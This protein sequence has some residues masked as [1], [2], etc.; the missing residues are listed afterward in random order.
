MSALTRTAARGTVL[1][2]GALLLLTASSYVVAVVLARGL[3]PVDYGVYGIIYS[4]LL[5]IELIGRLGITQAVAR[6]VAERGVLDPRLEGSGITLILLVNALI[7][8]AF[9]ASAGGLAELFNIP[10][11]GRFLF[12]VAAL[13]IPFYATYFVLLEILG[14]RRDFR[15]ESFGV[16]VYSL[17]KVAGV[18]VL[19]AVGPTITGGLLLN[20]AA[21]IAGLACLVWRVG[22]RSFRLNLAFRAPIIRLAIPVALGAI[23]TQLLSAI[24]LWSLNAIGTHVADDMKGIYVAATTLARFPNLIAFVLTAVLIPSVA[25][26]TGMGDPAL[27]Q[28][29]IRGTMRFLAITLI[30]ACALLAIEAKPVM[31]LLFSPE[32]SQGAVLLR[33]LV[34]AHGLFN[35]TFL[36]LIAILVAV[37]EPRRGAVIALA[38]LPVAVLANWLLIALLGAP[39]A[40][41]AALLATMTAAAAATVVVWRRVG[42]VLEPLVL[43]KTLLATAVVGLAAALIPS[44]G[45]MTLVE[46]AGLGIAFL[47]LASLLGL[48]TRADLA[49]FLP[50]KLGIGPGS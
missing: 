13:D 49:P 27:V 38:V 8:A 48:V 19:A 5:S 36:T 21:S 15:A 6:L 41:L 29:T 37:D 26:A 30:P 47:G 45:L 17:A 22:R 18:A 10:E 14:G 42:P 28:A 11:N 3:G 12:R 1:M 4:F 44:G 43:A 9:L 40:A 25:R 20:V 50:A 46:L 32:F 2:S 16:V 31:A 39:G 34:F 23:G 35:T 24:D 33:I 7:F